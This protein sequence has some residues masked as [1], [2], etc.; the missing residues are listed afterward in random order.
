MPV[1][2]HGRDP[3]RTPGELL[4]QLAGKPPWGL[5]LRLYLNWAAGTG[6]QKKNPDPPGR[7]TQIRPSTAAEAH[8][9]GGRGRGVARGVHFLA[10]NV[11]LFC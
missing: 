4:Q 1:H 9:P 7:G 10:E 8:F 3:F 5:A 2:D 6:P 11:C